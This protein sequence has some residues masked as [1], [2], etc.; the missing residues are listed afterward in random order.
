MKKELI[1]CVLIVILI[2]FG[3][4]I[5]QKYTKKVVEE[6]KESLIELKENNSKKNIDDVYNEFFDK[7]KILAFYLEHDEIEKVETSLTSIKGYI[8]VNEEDEAIVEME[9]TIYIL[10]HIKNKNRFNLQNIF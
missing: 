1:I 3:E 7:H 4:F 6:T 8:E 10:E 9:K 2:F 5:T